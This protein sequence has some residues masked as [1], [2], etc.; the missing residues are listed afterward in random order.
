MN[1]QGVF[2]NFDFITKSLLP[3]FNTKTLSFN[4]VE[5]VKRYE[6]QNF[7]RRKIGLIIM[8]FFFGSAL[9]YHVSVLSSILDYFPTY[10]VVIYYLIMSNTIIF[11]IIGIIT[12]FIKNP[13]KLFRSFMIILVINSSIYNLYSVCINLVP[14]ADG[15]ADS[16]AAFR[17]L[18]YY[19]LT[20]YFLVN[21]FFEFKLFRF[22]LL[23]IFTILIIVLVAIYGG[24]ALTIIDCFYCLIISLY[25]DLFGY[26]MDKAGKSTLIEYLQNELIGD[27][28]INILKQMNLG[29]AVYKNEKLKFS[30]PKFFECFGDKDISNEKLSLS[31]I[32]IFIEQ[33]IQKINEIDKVTLQDSQ[34]EGNEKLN[35]NR[36][37]SKLDY[38]IEQNDL[39]F[40]KVGILRFKNEMK[41]EKIYEVYISCHLINQYKITEIL[42][43]DITDTLEKEKMKKD[44][45]IKS[46]FLAKISH[47]FTSPLI[48]L[49]EQ[50]NELE[51]INE[52]NNTKKKKIINLSEY[53]FILLKE[54]TFCIEERTNNDTENKISNI[55]KS[56]L[57]E[58]NTTK[59]DI[60]QLTNKVLNL[61][62]SVKE[63]N[64]IKSKSIQFTFNNLTCKNKYDI[65]TDY[66]ILHNLI[67]MIL[68]TL[69]KLV[70]SGEIKVS[71]MSSSKDNLFIEIDCKTN[72]NFIDL[73][74][75]KNKNTKEEDSY[76]KIQGVDIGL[77]ICKNYL[78]ILDLD[79]LIEQVKDELMIKINLSL[80]KCHLNAKHKNEQASNLNGNELNDNDQKNSKFQNSSSYSLNT[81]KL[82]DN[83]EFKNYFNSNKEL[84]SLIK[85]NNSNINLF[86][87]N[88]NNFWI[89]NS[90]NQFN[91]NLEIGISLNNGLTSDNNNIL[92]NNNIHITNNMLS[93]QCN[94]SEKSI[95]LNSNNK[96][97]SNS[98]RKCKTFIIGDDMTDIR[99]SIKN[100]LLQIY[101]NEEINI[102]ECADGIEII[103]EIYRQFISGNTNN[104]IS[105]VITDQYM[106]FLNG[107]DVLKV[108][109]KLSEENKIRKMKTVV[110]TAFLDSSNLNFIQKYN[111][112]KLLN[113]PLSKQQLTKLLKDFDLL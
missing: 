24:T 2:N 12:I 20:L 43:Y 7:L 15:T 98:L 54:L 94:L 33:N 62:N 85:S 68:L 91:N 97:N 17:A 23:D 69:L 87:N 111:P 102:I 64:A 109:N 95:K 45:T 77:A 104:N 11:P 84:Y 93:N 48:S 14:K 103:Y 79:A 47:E 101:A 37:Y 13:N 30:N 36:K 5:L 76:D 38:M 81:T 113:K 25:F 90:K 65:V 71:L 96:V 39:K 6:Q 35:I 55:S 8:S 1:S 32:Q 66:N 53:L 82:M 99:N 31:R 106:N 27:Y 83:F 28:F 72:F 50:V 108:I 19:I 75:N 70:Y 78:N 41:I 9:I 52:A 110:L 74:Y 88:N 44:F 86:N 18:Q 22:F 21:F 92:I 112:D 61:V 34:T 89:N 46:K 49:K 3:K 29:L 107:T 10:V 80:N 56:N 4:D 40:N 63:L 26:F 58:I 105:C 67:S 73:Y 100:L 51:S 59:F 16:L 42:V 57:I 60:I